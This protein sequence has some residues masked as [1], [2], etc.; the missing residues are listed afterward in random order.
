MNRFKSI[1]RNF[2]HAPQIR[3][4]LPLV[5]IAVFMMGFSLSFLVLVDWG[6]DPY[7]A[8]N[9]A[10]ISKLGISLG[11]WQAIFNTTLFLIVIL[12]GGKDI[13]W[14]TVANML[15]IGYLVDF[16]SWVWAKV[17]PPDFFTAN[18]PL[19]ITVMFLAVVVFV[20]SAALYMTGG[21]GVSPYD[22][23][24]FIILRRFPKLPMRG[25][26]I[27]YDMTAFLLSILLGGKFYP[28]TLCMVILLGPVIQFVGKLLAKLIPMPEGQE[29]VP[30]S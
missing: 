2:T 19:R 9:L 6:T 7:T 14:G 29:G 21:L 23:I 18:L 1:L 26:R 15:L 27:C 8:M 28:A 5:L 16:F 17:F 25:L 22:A 11:N 12:C 4:R 24:P 13:G 20:I 10:I 30:V 3:I